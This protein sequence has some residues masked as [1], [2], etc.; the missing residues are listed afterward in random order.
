MTAWTEHQSSSGEIPSLN[1]IRAVSVFIVLLSH[2][3]FEH[4]VPGGLGVTTFFFLSGYLITT[5]LLREHAR[6]GSIDIY[7]FYV[8]RFFR[9]MPPL[10]ITLVI[11][12]GLT[13]AGILPGHITLEGIASQL[14]YFANYLEVFFQGSE[15]VPT[16]TS[17]LW[18]LAVEEHF[19]MV[20]P[21]LMSIAFA[22]GFSGRA[23]ILFAAAICILVLGWRCHLVYGLGVS[24]VRTYYASDT[25]IDSIIYGCILAFCLWP[26]KMRQPNSGRM[27]VGDH[28]AL[29]GAGL[30][31]LFTFVY[32]D[33]QFR[34]TFR[35]SIQGIALMPIFYLAVMKPQS[36]P[37]VLLNSRIAV[38]IGIY[39][40]SIYL[41]HRVIIV[42]LVDNYPALGGQPVLQAAFAFILSLA[43]AALI[44]R[45]VDSYF[46]RQRAAFHRTPTV[47]PVPVKRAAA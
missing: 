47:D 17:V 23:K 5:L 41:I 34:E 11:A 39:S 29:A 18:S 43:Y 38:R 6:F 16:G 2:A 45:F 4:F 12:Y 13:F 31:L 3:G 9:L 46:R 24:D 26:P 33:P 40:Y 15:R 28:I 22:A 20:F 14:L 32:R 30:L 19:Y 35:Y 10:L 25:R 36:W 1:G 44:D 37:F 42:A 21:V 27:T 8:R 7:A